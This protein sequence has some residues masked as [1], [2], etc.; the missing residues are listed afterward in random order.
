MK[1]KRSMLT[2]ALSHPNTLGKI[3]ECSDDGKVT[4]KKTL[5]CDGKLI[6]VKQGKSW[7]EIM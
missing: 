4:E 3:V 5:L 7:K 2:L 6:A 1:R